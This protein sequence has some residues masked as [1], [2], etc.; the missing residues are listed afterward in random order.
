MGISIYVYF[1][2]PL[3]NRQLELKGD[4]CEFKT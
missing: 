4:V 1:Y 3:L 2:S